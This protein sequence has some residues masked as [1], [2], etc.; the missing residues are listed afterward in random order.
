MELVCI[1]CP[2]GCHLSAQRTENG[3]ITV[4]G[5]TCARGAKFAE[6]EMTHP[7]RSLT[8][9][10]ATA[11]ADMPMLPVRTDGEIPKEKINDVMRVCGKFLLKNPVQCGDVVL[12]NAA[13]TGC[14]LIATRT[15]TLP[16]KECQP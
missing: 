12:E 8:T 15:I 3:S 13:D 14:D 11:F 5:N 6:S 7:M 9:T 4:T 1:V 16:P 2:Q 10:V